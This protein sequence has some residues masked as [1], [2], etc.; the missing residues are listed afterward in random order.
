[1][2]FSQ[3]ASMGR[4][5][6]IQPQDV[7]RQ[8]A[9]DYSSVIRNVG[10]E[11]SA[12]DKVFGSGGLFIP[13]YVTPDGQNVNPADVAEDNS[14]LVG[15]TPIFNMLDTFLAGDP[16]FSHAFVLSD[17]GMGKT[18]L[19]VILKMA[20]L[21]RL[22]NDTFHVELLKL[23]EASAEQIQQ[24][25]DPTKTVLLLDALDEDGGAWTSFYSR[26][27][28]LLQIAQ[29]FRKTII[30]CRTQFFPW[31]Q[32]QDGKAPGLVKLHGFDCSKVFLSPFD[33]DQVTE[34]LHKRFPD[35]P[36]ME[37]AR[38]IVMRMKSLKFRPMLLSYVDLLLGKDRD[39][40]NAFEMYGELID[41]WLDRELKKGMIHDK[42]SLMHACEKIAVEM[43]E[44]KDRLIDASRIQEI[45]ATSK[46]LRDLEQMSVEGRS[47]LHR[48]SD[49]GYKFAHY[50]VLEY[51][52]CRWLIQSHKPIRTSDQ[53]KSFLVD[54]LASGQLRRLQNLDMSSTVMK[55]L[56]LRSVEA[57]AA[58]FDNGLMLQCDFAHGVFQNAS[59]RGSTIERCDLRNANFGHA[60][61][62]G[63]LLDTIE[64]GG[65]KLNGVVFKRVTGKE[66][67]FATSEIEGIDFE[68]AKFSLC[69]FQGTRLRNVRFVR[70][71]MLKSDFTKVDFEKCLM[72]DAIYDSSTFQACNA[73]DTVFDK[74]RMD[75]CVFKSGRLTRSSFQSA[76]LRGAC[77]DEAELS[78]AVFRKAGAGQATFLHCIATGVDFSEADLMSTTFSGSALQNTI[79]TKANLSTADFGNAEMHSANLEGARVSAVNFDGAHLKETR[80]A[81][82]TGTNTSFADADLVGATCEGVVLDQGDFGRANLRD[83]NWRNSEITE[84]DF[85]ESDIHGADF[86]GCDLSGSDF[87]AM[88]LTVARTQGA[89]FSRIRCVRGRLMIIGA[90]DFA[91]AKLSESDMR[92][93]EANNADLSHSDLSRAQLTASQMRNVKFLSATLRGTN[94]SQ[95]N[96]EGANFTNADLRGANAADARL[97]GAIFRDTLVDHETILPDTVSTNQRN[98][99][100]M[101]G[102]GATF[103]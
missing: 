75:G 15:K 71:E 79:F 8:V 98:G 13:F 28:E 96:L 83:T 1:M 27:Q 54:I 30:T 5:F 95:V 18:S 77:F 53:I 43:Y 59:F 26:V 88:D 100:K 2:T 37:Q 44:S 69:S 32:E 34:Y 49:G 35:A 9:T 73:I 50:T 39:Y 86:R 38:R 70:S 92:G 82:I 56:K 63:C 22:I 68:G 48:T 45:C 60:V 93:S 66:L 81:G 42:E 24:I 65:A 64:L 57:H 33:D 90:A 89:K 84:S 74:A 19:L 97:E 76:L 78:G 91:G 55:G 46:N 25:K 103:G 52:V 94:L 20:H 40:D 31:K 14:G 72:N 16:R 102:T 36:T 101:E 51:F 7:A 17:A 61:L 4:F 23:G 10:D 3:G 29:H 67:N 62:E 80:L 87:S 12:I 58:V 41:A 85:R 6:K 99:L 47:M 11:V 21:D